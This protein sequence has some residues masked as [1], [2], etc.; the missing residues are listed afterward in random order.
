MSTNMASL[1]SLAIALFG[2]ALAGC[3]PVD[4]QDTDTTPPVTPPVGEQLLVGGAITLRG[5]TS[6]GWIVYSDNDTLT[7]HATSIAGGEPREIVAL[8]NDFAISVWGKV[9]FAWPSKSK[10]AVAP[11]T[12][13]TADGGAHAVSQASLAP[14]VAASMDGSTIVYLDGV[15]AAGQTGRL[16]A[17][18]G[19]GSNPHVL[20]EGL[21][22]LGKDGCRALLGFAG[23]Y[24]LAAHCGG[25]ATGATITSFELPSWKRT[26]LA[27]GAAN[28]WSTDHLGTIVLT[29]TSAGTVVVPIGGGAPVTIDP[30]G[31][32]GVLV[33]NGESAIYGASTNELRRSP[34][35]SPSPMTL[36]GG[37]GGLYG[38]SPDEGYVL[39]YKKMD[40][41]HLISDMYLGSATEP[42]TPLTLS[43]EQAAGVHGD[44]FTLDGSRVLYFTGIDPSSQ[45]GT[46][47]AL[48]LGEATPTV[49]AH[50][51]SQTWAATKSKIVF[52]DHYAWT[53]LRVHADV[54]SF[55]TAKSKEPTL[56]VNQ[57]DSEVFLS[58]SREQV[59]YT[60]SLDDG[61]RAGIYVVDIP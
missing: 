23:S 11:L 25:G 12:V 16:V 54:W 48:S 46:L 27:S 55:D 39:F 33:A 20:L 52:N 56:I 49:V 47:N 4:S 50:G 37:A 26:D 8:G 21:T 18:G 38:V 57:A 14:W 36:V 58:P 32:T 35:G 2:A 45:T 53:G 15:D 5:M 13:W 7:L 61:P 51:V 40:A 43:A 24:V 29:A 3:V 42:S 19:D 28:E 41:T 44:A 30:S 1:R 31:S 6:D 59:V 9:V 60:W 10:A 22:G 17:A 34:V